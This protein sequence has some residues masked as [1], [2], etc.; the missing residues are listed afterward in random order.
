MSKCCASRARQSIVAY[1][2]SHVGL[3]NYPTTVGQQHRGLKGRNILQ[4]I[5]D[6]CHAARHRRGDL[7]QLDLRSLGG[8]PASRMAD[9]DLC[10][11]AAR[12]RGTSRSAVSQL[13]VPRIRACVRDRNL[14][15]VP[16]RRNSLRHDLLAVALLLSHCQKRFKAKSAARFPRSNWLDQ[17]WIAFQRKRERW[18]IEFA[19]V[20]TQPVASSNPR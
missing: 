20:A 15:H 19:A 4:E 1:G 5:I 16:V 17:R 3:F 12:R 11:Q 13:A 14:R 2:H 8:R 7:H 10:R 6:R 9:G 18:L